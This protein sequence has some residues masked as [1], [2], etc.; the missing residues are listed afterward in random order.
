MKL[1]PCNEPEFLIPGNHLLHIQKNT[2]DSLIRQYQIYE[3]DEKQYVL[4][5]YLDCTT[6]WFEVID[7]TE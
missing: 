2:I 3:F 5:L 4:F 6:Q 7:E 1:K